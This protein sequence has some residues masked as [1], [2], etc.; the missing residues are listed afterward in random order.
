MREQH[1]LSWVY[2]A[3]NLELDGCV[4][5]LH[6]ADGSEF[7][8]SLCFCLLWRTLDTSCERTVIHKPTLSCMSRPTKLTF[9][10]LWSFG[11]TLNELISWFMP[12]L[13]SLLKRAPS[14]QDM[15]TAHSWE[16]AWESRPTRTET[17]DQLSPGI[18]YHFFKQSLI[19]SKMFSLRR[20]L[21][22]RLIYLSLCTLFGNI[23]YYY[24]ATS[25]LF[26][27]EVL[28]EHQ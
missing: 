5:H 9:I 10:N 22:V 11:Q 23:S 16:W 12:K 15:N 14:G 27:L 19:A 7:G 8:V 4:K 17:S 3:S 24:F 18:T 21:T 2:H 6:A 28:K 20:S 25:K 26:R 13:P 1:T